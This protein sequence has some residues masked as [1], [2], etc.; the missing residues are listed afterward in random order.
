MFACF[1][2]DAIITPGGEPEFWSV[3]WLSWLMCGL[4]NTNIMVQKNVFRLD[5]SI[6]NKIEI[7]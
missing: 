2:V 7:H 4:S 6:V 1:R 3:L 5:N